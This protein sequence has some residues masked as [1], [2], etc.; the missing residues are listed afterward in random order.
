[1]NYDEEEMEMVHLGDDLKIPNN[2]SSRFV[3]P[4][5]RI[6]NFVVEKQWET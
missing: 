5:D 2:Q 6:V 4:D 3:G 1:L